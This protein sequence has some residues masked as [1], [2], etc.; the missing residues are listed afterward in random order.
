MKPI[1]FCQSSVLFLCA[2]FMLWFSCKKIIPPVDT[3]APIIAL[4]NEDTIYLPKG[5]T[6]AEF[7]VKA[8]DDYD[9]DC[10]ASIKSNWDSVVNLYKLGLFEVRFSASDRRNNISQ[11]KK[12]LRIIYNNYLPEGEFNC[13]RDYY[14]TDTRIALKDT[15]F[16]AF[17]I[18]RTS[19][20]D[21]YKAVMTV[22]PPFKIYPYVCCSPKQFTFT[23]LKNDNSSFSATDN[24]LF[25]GKGAYNAATKQLRI[26]L[27]YSIQYALNN[28]PS[29]RTTYYLDLTKTRK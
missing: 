27:T 25:N 24:D 3:E 19:A 10:T 6:L 20:P 16:C 2:V 14:Y 4:P 1:N 9:G 15:A 21:T 11:T 17:A 23:A 29:Y 5:T 18:S 13:L 26:V 22:V 8:F 7:G 28:I 12:H